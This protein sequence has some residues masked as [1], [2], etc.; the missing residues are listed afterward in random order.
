MLCIYE[1]FSLLYLY[2]YSHFFFARWLLVVFVSLFLFFLCISIDFTSLGVLIVIIL[3]CS[4][5]IQFEY[6]AHYR[7]QHH[8]IEELREIKNYVV[9]ALNTKK[10]THKI[11]FDIRQFGCYFYC[12]MY[13]ISLMMLMMVCAL[14]V[15]GVCVSVWMC[16]YISLFFSPIKLILLIQCNRVEPLTFFLFFRQPQRQHTRKRWVDCMGVDCLL[17]CLC[18]SLSVAVCPPCM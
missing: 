14:S 7:S 18:F 8:T 5:L 15:C 11:V 6:F 16:G 4:S 10:N 17:V 3:N 9:L 13:I 2:I 12:C 1:F